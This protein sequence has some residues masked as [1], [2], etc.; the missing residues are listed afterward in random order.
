[1]TE[2][3]Q[4]IT[5]LQ[6][7]I[8]A[9]SPEKRALFERLRASQV[10]IGKRQS[11]DHSPLS[12]AQERLWFLHQLDPNNPAYNIA[13]LWRFEGQF[14]IP[15]LQ[16][17]FNQIV[18]RHESLRTTFRE[19]SG[20]PI[21]VI[22]SR[23]LLV[24]PIVDLRTLPQQSRLVE[25]E[26][27]AKQTASYP[28][29]LAEV[30]LLRTVVLQL[31]D[32][33]TILLLTL[34][35]IVADGWSRG[36]LLRELTALYKA[37]LTG[38][39]ASLP[40]LPIQYADFAVW[41]RQQ[42]FSDQIAYWQ[43]QLADLQPLVLP[44]DYPRP[45][46]S[47]FH[48]ATQSLTLP[49]HLLEALKSLSRQS[50]VTLFM[51]LLTAFKV[52]LHRYSQQNDIAVGVPTA[53]RSQAEVE[54]L[55]GFFVNTLVLRTD[56]S[57][58]PSFQTLLEKVRQVTASAYQHQDLPFAKLVDVLHPQRHLS[59]NPLFQVMFQFQNQVYE[60]QNALTPNLDMPDLR[61][62]QDWIN[63][64]FTKFDLTW[65]LVDRSQGLLVVVEYRT[66]LYHPDTVTRML[67]HFQVLLE[68]IIDIPNQPISEL[69]I[70]TAAERQQILLDWNQT[71]TDAGLDQFLPNRFEAQVEHT[72]D[73][74][75]VIFQDR[76]V[77][78][79]ELN[80][81]A[82]QLAH[83]L[84][85]QHITTESRVGICMTRSVEMIIALLGVL[86][87]G[88]AYVPLDPG[89]PRERLSWMIQD[90]QV[91]LLLI[92][93]DIY[94]DTDCQIFSIIHNWNLIAA[95]PQYNPNRILTSLNLAYLIYTS[96]STG[97]PK[98][99]ML[100]HQG[101]S[102]YLNWCLYYF[103]DDFS[104]DAKVDSAVNHFG[105]P[106]QS[107]VS[108]DATI[109][110]LYAPLLLGQSIVLLPEQAALEALSFALT[111]YRFSL[112][113][114][115]PAHLRLLSQWQIKADTHTDTQNST[116]FV[117]GGEALTES[118]LADWRVLAPK[119]KLVNE[120]GPTETVVGCC[121]H[122]VSSDLHAVSD[123]QSVPIG[124]PI[125]NTKLYIL[126]RYL[127]PVPVGIPG[128][129]YIAGVGV[130]R[131]Y[132][133]RPALT[134]EKFVPNP[135]VSNFSSYSR[136]YRTGDLARY[137]ADGTIEYLGRIDQQVKL[138][139]FRIELEEVISVLNQHPLVKDSTVV[140]D[141]TRD[142]LVAYVVMQAGVTET[143]SDGTQPAPSL[144]P[145]LRQNLREF[146]KTKLP[147]YML[148][149]LF[150]SLS[151]LPLTT[152]GKIDQS[153]LPTH[154]VPAVSVTELP[155][156]DVE[157]QLV[158]IWTE[159]LGVSVSIHD[160]FFELGGDS[161]LSLQVIAQAKQVGLNFTP[162]QMFQHQTIAELAAQ[163]NTTKMIAAEQGTVTGAVP[164]TPIQHWLLS[165][166]LPELHHYNQALLL[167]V[168][169]T[170]EVD[171]LR[172]ALT[173]LWQHHDALR[174]QLVFD[175]VGIHSVHAA[176]E[177]PIRFTVID[178]SFLPL[179]RKVSTLTAIADSLQSSLHLS[180][181]LWRSI[182]FRMGDDQ[183]ARLLLIL[184]H[185]IIDGVSW[186]ILIED[187]ALVYKQ[188]KQGESVQLPSKTTAYRDWA[189]HLIAQ[190]NSTSILSELD[191]WSSCQSTL[192]LPIDYSNPGENIVA[193]VDQIRVSLDIEFTRRL[194]EDVPKTHHA[195]I[196]EILLAAFAHASQ[197][198]L[199]TG[200]ILID[201]ESHGR[202]SVLGDD[203][204][205]DVSRTVGWFTAISPVSLQMRTQPLIETLKQ[206]KE[207]L[208]Q[209]PN[210]GLGYGLLRYLSQNAAQTR[211]KQ[212]PS[213]QIKFNY[214]GQIDHQ[215]QAPD[216]LIL[217]WAKESYGRVNSP[218]NLRPYLL[219]INAWI[220]NQ[221][222]QLSWA[223][224]RSYH[225]C[226]TI[227][228][229]AQAYLQALTTL[230]Q[231]Q[232]S[233]SYTPS[234]FPAARVSQKQLD[235]LIRK[236]Q[237]GSSSHG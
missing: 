128:E 202:Y 146:L 52:L 172:Q 197:Y 102:N 83:Y 67:G 139:G 132:F 162:R 188:L 91:E 5:A 24:L 106:V 55:I 9:L 23:Q 57:G 121:V 77:T 158:Q 2:S 68:G 81:R 225:H 127:Q 35:H 114:L 12:F 87:A 122:T 227:E 157:A 201:L 14:N 152:N 170:V 28:F 49:P 140:V 56:L 185:W 105:A 205:I 39:P 200:T 51:T 130:A 160:N 235:Q 161:I 11:Q 116:T 149:T 20:Q 138:H 177:T 26:R 137:L 10:R 171:Y 156:T 94:L 212:L 95:Y 226:N 147:D 53:N 234:D 13:I 108:F 228:R 37:Y 61:L 63:T 47:Q 144:P 3:R 8:A 72:P 142:C 19:D 173:Y 134:A 70:L 118:H 204:D 174:L 43:Q 150:V 206:V 31:S 115:T 89:Y 1:M 80:I 208:R 112:L 117:I 36:V 93:S 153:A 196:N 69:P 58:N 192:Q 154:V 178:L 22:V 88:A 163:V 195:Y 25:V 217:G 221:Q 236:L 123:T 198:W 62:S 17:C 97:Q 107:S 148:P 109:T 76:Q 66:D 180:G 186:R 46:V 209:M 101:L 222:L 232:Q 214:L 74:I 85:A 175:H 164:L 34:H 229:L 143:Q 220:A 120:Y 207:T 29:D 78:Y 155:S 126:D 100:T 103:S 159:L 231:N 215:N 213:A 73:R 216:S 92:Q 189:K 16:H 131:G 6:Q 182:V 90:A 45:P 233:V 165:Q 125:Y 230:I 184:H 193:F 40:A 191:Y 65:H 32:T 21:Q 41:Q 50:G 181:I 71:G 27:L 237:S 99:T 18:E 42:D 151:D 111:T 86:K 210:H 136:L 183:P 218:S 15:L 64:G 141:T 203:L 54:P 7:R 145:S 60:L 133:R 44:T 219:E 223:Y 75:A 84:Q 166:N 96:G 176:A 187:L 211:L 79:Q 129:L 124:K 190:A 38:Q 33:E 113:K 110:S 104:G 119:S 48:S 30:P 179:Q 135:F 59:Q 199:G 167:E 169:P 4:D 98:G 168:S 194:L 82:N 224:S